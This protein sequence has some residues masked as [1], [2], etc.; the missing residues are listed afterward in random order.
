MQARL[1]DQGVKSFYSN[2]ENCNCVWLQELDWKMDE[3]TGVLSDIRIVCEE[4][5]KQHLDF[6]FVLIV[7]VLFRHNFR[8][9]SAIK[10]DLY[11]K[12]GV[13]FYTIVDCK[14]ETVAVLT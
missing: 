10:F 2:S 13:K 6:P 14:K 1:I 5:K 9:D 3:T 11:W 4:T 8:N 12:Q 7:E